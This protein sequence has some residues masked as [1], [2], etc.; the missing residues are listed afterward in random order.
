MSLCLLAPGR[1]L[2]SPFHWMVLRSTPSL[3]SSYRGDI[4]RRRCTTST[5]RLP[6]KSTS[7][8]VEN[9]CSPK[10]IEEWSSSDYTAAS[11]SPDHRRR[12]QGRGRAGGAR[13]EGRLLV[14]PHEHRFAF[15][16]GEGDIQVVGQ[17]AR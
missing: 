5:T 12:L 8:S 17:S 9:R 11:E 6:T 10:R 13:G 4:S 14:E 15:H 3:A 2:Y 7:S 1:R 16:V